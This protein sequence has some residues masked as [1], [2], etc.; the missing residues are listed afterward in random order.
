MAIAFVAVA[1][2]GD[3]SSTNLV[4][5]RPAAGNRAV[6]DVGVLDL[7]IE[8]STKPGFNNSL[9]TWTDISSKVHGG[10]FEHYRY[11]ERYAST[12]T[13]TFAATWS[14]GNVAAWRTAIYTL[15]RGVSTNA[16]PFD[17]TPTHSSNASQAEADI[18][19]IT[20]TENNSLRHA[21][22]ADFDGRTVTFQ[23]GW[24]TRG[25]LGNLAVADQV[26]TSSGA[27][28][29]STATLSAASINTCGHHGFLATAGGGAAPQP[30]NHYRN[31]MGV[32]Q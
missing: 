6:D 8:T 32:G 31:L 18:L 14:A 10:G 20:L 13:S 2:A 7:Y 1:T 29:D 22:E 5:T 4:I 24:S 17:G 19:G 9:G 3:A 23:A 12:V 16:S 30:P 11:Y 26:V 15:Y 28:G 27:T 21:G 25:D